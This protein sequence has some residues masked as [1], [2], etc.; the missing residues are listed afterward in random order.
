M[1]T[2]TF[3]YHSEE[4]RRAIEAAIAFVAEMHHLALSAP[5]GQVLPLCEAQ[6]LDQGR[7]LLRCTLQQAVQARI[8]QTEKKGA[9]LGSAPAR[10]RSA[11]SGDVRGT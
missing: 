8:D 9:P 4:E 5:E 6:A 11:S 3:E 7:H 1:P 10:A 2:G